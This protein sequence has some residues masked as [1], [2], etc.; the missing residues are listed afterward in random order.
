M[1]NFNK[2]K[3]QVAFFLS[4]INRT[5]PEQLEEF[6]ENFKDSHEDKKELKR[7]DVVDLTGPLAAIHNAVQKEVV[8]V[9]AKEKEKPGRFTFDLLPKV[10]LTEE[11]QEDL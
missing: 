8:V 5:C 7:L 4:P 9:E 10:D 11:E 6:L 2:F 1:A 3:R